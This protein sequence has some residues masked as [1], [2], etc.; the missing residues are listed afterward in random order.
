[1]KRQTKRRELPEQEEEDTEGE[2]EERKRDAERG[3]MEI[4]VRQVTTSNRVR[5]VQRIIYKDWR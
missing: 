5:S 2:E 3:Q 1:M 4:L